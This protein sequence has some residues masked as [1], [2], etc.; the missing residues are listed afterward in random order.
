MNLKKYLPVLVLLTLIAI[1][2]DAQNPKPENN[3]DQDLRGQI[4]NAYNTA[5]HNGGAFWIAYGIT[6]KVDRQMFM[7]SYYFSGENACP[8]LK[9]ILADPQKYI[10]NNLRSSSSS[11]KHINNFV[12]TDHD[13]S[14]KGDLDKVTAVLFKYESDSKNVYD[15]TAISVCNLSHSFDTDGCPITWLGEK[16]NKSSLEYLISVYK[17]VDEINTKKKLLP[18]VGIHTGQPEAFAFLKN[19]I[20]SNSEIELRK[21]AVFAIG[22]QNSKE[23]LEELKHV[24]NDGK[25]IEVRKN[26]VFS[27]GS[28][29]LPEV[30]DELINILRHN[31]SDEIRK[32]AVFALGNKAIEKAREALKNIVETDPDIE[33]KKFAVYALANNS[34]KNILYLI[35]VAKTN[36]SLEIRKCA[37]WS[38]GNSKDKE[39]IDALIDMAKN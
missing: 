36:P 28:I 37:I 9:E 11:K 4:E 19:V 25:S 16:S 34:E 10:H 23:A 1:K 39:A 18:A 22:M 24:I 3:N 20:E 7:G 29:E 15:F 32:N 2:A 35:E 12:W 33:I 5:K 31:T 38:L 21:M 17:N 13:K 8:T 14:I 26:A 27:L 6:Q 30:T